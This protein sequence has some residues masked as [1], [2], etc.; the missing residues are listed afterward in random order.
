MSKTC[1]WHVHVQ[2]P[3]PCPCPCLRHVRVQDMSMSKTCPSQRPLCPSLSCPLFSLGVR[4]TPRLLSEIRDIWHDREHVVSKDG[5][6]KLS[7]HIHKIVG[8]GQHWMNEWMCI[9]I[10][11]MSHHRVRSNVSLWR[12]LRLPPSVHFWS[13]SPH[14]EHRPLLFPT[15]AWVL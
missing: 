15:S 10:P 14:R 8:F 11:H 5:I 4:L 13:H 6:N 1:P 12:H 2:C 9:Y 7:L 3:S